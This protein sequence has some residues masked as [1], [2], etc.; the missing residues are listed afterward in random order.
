MVKLVEVRRMLNNYSL[1][2]IYVN[3]EHVVA[4][5]SDDKTREALI[6]G[7]LP[8]GLNQGQSFTTLYLDR[9]QT[10]IDVVVV[11]DVETIKEKLGIARRTL[12]KG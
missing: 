2:E 1:S 6:E 7:R 3:P 8:T 11:G 5:R 9:G 10:G 12:L 4:I